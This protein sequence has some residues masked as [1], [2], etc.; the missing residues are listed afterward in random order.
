MAAAQP[1]AAPSPSPSLH[2]DIQVH[3]HPDADATQ[4]KEIFKNMAKYLYDKDIDE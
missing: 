4:V 1:I 3:I 2:I